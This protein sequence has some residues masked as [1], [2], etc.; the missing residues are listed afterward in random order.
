[1]KLGRLNHIGAATPSSFVVI[2]RNEVTKQSRTG[3]SIPG[4]F[5]SLAMTD[6]DSGK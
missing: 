4:C 2:A 5:A 1:M 6:L 3:Y